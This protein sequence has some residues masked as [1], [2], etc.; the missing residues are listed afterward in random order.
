MILRRFIQH[1][2]HQKWT[3]IGIELVI[4]VLGVFIGTQ[5]SNWNQK[6]STDQTAAAFTV[7]LKADLRGE[8]WDYQ[9]LTT[10]NREVLE[11]ADRAVNALDGNATLSDEALLVSAYRATQYRQRISN[12][13][14]YDELISTGTISLIRDRGLREAAMQH[15]NLTATDYL[16]RESMNSRYR[17]A[18]RMTVPNDVQ[19]ALVKQCGDR[20]FDAVGDYADIPGTLE[21]PCTTGLSEQAVAAAANALRTNI[22]LAPLLRA[23]IADIET[24]IVLTRESQAS[25]ERLRAIAKKKL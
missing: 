7:R 16:L 25:L 2:K 24:L 20:I 3:A 10:Y 5:V 17:E 4:V 21:Y 13:S 6:L 1:F 19:R 22:S 14:T 8:E 12:R 11:N 9:I 18:F 23:R 15:Y